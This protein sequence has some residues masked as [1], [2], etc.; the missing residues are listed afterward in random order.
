[1][2]WEDASQLLSSLNQALDSFDWTAAESLGDKISARIRT[3][4]D[5]FPEVS[6]K[7]LLA[8]LRRKQR[9]LTMAGIAE[10]LVQSGVRTPTVQRQY[11]QA[12]IDQGLLTPAE[13]MLRAV[14]QDPNAG[15]EEFEARGLIGRIYKQLYINRN[16]PKSPA[17]QNSL[18]RAIREYLSVY[19]LDPQQHVWHGINVVALSARAQRDGI[20]ISGL[21]DPK[22][23]AQEI[24]KTLDDREAQS[25]TS[26]DCWDVATRCEACIAIGDMSQCLSDALDYVEDKNADAFEISSTLRQYTE[27]WQLNDNEPPGNQLLPILRANLLKKRGAVINQ[28][29]QQVK[30]EVK[31]VSAAVNDLQGIYGEDRMVPLKWYRKGLEQCNSVARI[32]KLNGKGHGTGWLVNASDFF[33]NR[34]GLLLMTNAHVITDKF[35]PFGNNPLA[36]TPDDANVNFQALGDGHT[37]PL[38]EVVWTSP[39]EA[40]KFDATFVTIKGEL[41]AE[42]KGLTIHKKPVQMAQP[43]PRLYIIGHPGGRDLEI[44][45]QDNYLLGCTDRL[46]HYRTPTEHGSSG[47]PVFEPD[48]WRVVALH[49][50]GSSTMNRIDGQPGTYAANEGVAVLA[51]QKEPK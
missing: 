39:P 5:P 23:L 35:E 1:M 3:S 18:D 37:Y 9:F 24:R 17:N 15:A 33:P 12:L 20:S 47:S 34:T 21:P 6:A 27:V 50:K 4:A 8:N 42:A 10:S 19:R 41:P 31:T 40:D 48:D 29:F 13:S 32:E 51:I 26:L 16:D 38:G 49:H 22:T 43:T 7:K 30:Q 25:T 28:E 46:L 2:P 14:V 36:I 11:A 44:S 45:L